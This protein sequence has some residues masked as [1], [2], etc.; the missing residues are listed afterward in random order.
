MSLRPRRGG[1][2]VS[3]P[4]PTAKSTAIAAATEQS[5]LNVQTVATAAEEL[6]ASIDDIAQRAEEA[7]RVAEAASHTMASTAEQVARLVEATREIGQVVGLNRQH[8][9]S[10]Q[11]ARPQRHHRGGSRGGSGAGLFRRCFGSETARH[12][13]RKGDGGYCRPHFRHP[14]LDRAFG[15]ARSARSAT[16]SPA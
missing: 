3:P 10:N 9:Q 7:A 2:R 13:D 4:T 1:C 12:P 6:S 16:S 8:R 15:P 11:P 14:G 5:S